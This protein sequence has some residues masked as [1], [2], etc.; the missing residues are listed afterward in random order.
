MKMEILLSII[1]PIYNTPKIFLQNCLNSLHEQNLHNIEFILINDGSTVTWIDDT[2]ES[3]T[4]L[5]NRFKYYKKTNTGVADT[6]NKGIEYSQGEYIMFVDSDDQLMPN[7]CNYAINI[8]KKTNSD[9]VLLGKDSNNKEKDSFCKMLD[10]KEKQ[11]L[12]YSVLAFSSIYA[13]YNITIDSPW[14]KIFKRSIIRNNNIYFPTELLRSEDAVFCLYYYESSKSIY[15]DN[16]IIYKYV[17][18]PDSIC[19]KM[20]NVS[21]KMLPLILQV[22]EIFITKNNFYTQ[23][24]SSALKERTQ[25]GLDECFSSYFLHPDNKTKIWSLAKELKQL[26]E[27]P[28]V[29]K[30]FNKIEFSDLRGKRQKLYYGFLKLKMYRGIFFINKVLKSIQFS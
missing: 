2:V 11:N 12:M 17:I 25:K 26:I 5:D 29:N 18:N 3:I 28:I 24:F 6:R 13:N 10:E 19:R 27:T 30:Y 4:L 14:A 1:I 22:E 15:I 9:V 8:I 7:A 20:S 21:M 23:R 16:H